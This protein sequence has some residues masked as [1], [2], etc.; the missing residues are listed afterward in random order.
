MEENRSL[1]I[2]P[3]KTSI[4]YMMVS[5]IISIVI[6]LIMLFYPGGTFRVFEVAFKVFQVGISIFVAYYALTEFIYY[7]KTRKT[8]LAIVYLLIGIAAVTLIWVIDISLIFYIVAAFFLLTGIIEIIGSFQ[9]PQARYLFIILGFIN[10]LLGMIIIR[11]PNVLPF[12]FAWYVLF[13]GF[14]RFFLTLALRQVNRR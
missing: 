1:V 2:G 10:I 12:L 6:G 4:T 11:H 9:I 7:L 8:F 13:W 14:S 5:A 3:F